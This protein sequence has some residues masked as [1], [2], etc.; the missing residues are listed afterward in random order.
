M[1]SRHLGLWPGGGPEPGVLGSGEGV[2]RRDP[3]KT[4]AAPMIP[5]LL[6]PDFRQVRMRAA[7]CA[8]DR[9]D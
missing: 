3:L 8:E 6:A 7:V 5:G 2:D 4:S 1:K 9:A